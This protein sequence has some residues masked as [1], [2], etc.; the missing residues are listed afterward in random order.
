MKKLLLIAII[1]V[2]AV[3]TMAPAS[4]AYETR[5]RQDTRD[6][7]WADFR[8]LRAELYQLDIL[9][10]RV[11]SRMR[12]GGR[13]ESRWEYSRL[14]RDRQRLN[15]D[16]ERRPLDRLR[17]HS[18]IDRLRDQLRELDVRLRVRSHRFYR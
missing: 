14:V 1:A 9:F 4:Q 7:R 6:E 18:Q 16:L 11:A 5:R 12:Y 13:G 10:S 17:I 2:T 3:T 15:F 8:Q